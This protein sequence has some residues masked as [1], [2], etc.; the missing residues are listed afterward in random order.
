[1]QR[2]KFEEAFADETS[3]N[4]LGAMAEIGISPWE[5]RSIRLSAWFRA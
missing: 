3:W 4:L 2:R 1:M 5:L